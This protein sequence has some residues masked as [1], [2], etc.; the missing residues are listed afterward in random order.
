MRETGYSFHAGCSM[1]GGILTV[2]RAFFI[3]TP[4][5][6]GKTVEEMRF[7]MRYGLDITPAEREGIWK[8]HGTEFVT[9]DW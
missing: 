5:D 8:R 6:G 9:R 7:L 1:A 4:G 2:G 3:F